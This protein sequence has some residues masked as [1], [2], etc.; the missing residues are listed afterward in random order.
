M[1]L[2][3]GL[4]DSPQLSPTVT[5]EISNVNRAKRAWGTLKPCYK[6]RNTPSYFLLQK[7]AYVHPTSTKKNEQ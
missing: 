3:R 6:R 7:I 5:V 1:N 4:K 2:K